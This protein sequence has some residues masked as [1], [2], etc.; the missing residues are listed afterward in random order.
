MGAGWQRWW[1]D[2]GKAE[3]AAYDE[4]HGFKPRPPG[5]P[6]IVVDIPPLFFDP[7]YPPD[8]ELFFDSNDPEAGWQSLTNA[9]SPPPAA[10]L[11]IAN[12]LAATEA[13]KRELPPP[14]RV[15]EHEGR[16]YIV[17]E[18]TRYLFPEGTTRAQALSVLSEAMNIAERRSL[19]LR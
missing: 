9:T 5:L 11:T 10:D 12:M 7:Q 1:R 6:R 13:L 2:G 3:F 15:A 8:G 16:V 14:P 17:I 18:K 4:V 19:S